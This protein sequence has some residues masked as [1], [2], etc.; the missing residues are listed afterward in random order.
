VPEIV[1]TPF[2]SIELTAHLAGITPAEAYAL[3][4]QSDRLQEWWPPIAEVEARPG[5][6]YH[7]Q[8]PSQSWHLHGSF[9]DVQPGDHLAFTWRW[10]HLP[11]DPDYR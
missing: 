10:D 11:A 8:W 1:D 2:P 7:L 6:S 4:T 9:H 3:W 5:G